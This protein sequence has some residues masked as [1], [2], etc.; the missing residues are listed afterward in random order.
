MAPATR[1]GVIGEVGVE[2]HEHRAGKVTRQVGRATVRRHDGPAH[3]Q[4]PDISQPVSEFGGRDEHVH[5]GDG[6]R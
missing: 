3:V 6:T 5:T 2:I 4:Q 1:G